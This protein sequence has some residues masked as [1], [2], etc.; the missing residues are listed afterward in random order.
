MAVSL[1]DAKKNIYKIDMTKNEFALK[2][3]KDSIQDKY[4]FDATKLT[5]YLNDQE[6]LDDDLITLDQLTSE[7]RIDN[8]QYL[9]IH[10]YYDKIVTKETI[11]QLYELTEEDKQKK[12]NLP[13]M[14]ILP[15]DNKIKEYNEVLL[16]KAVN[17]PDDIS[18]DF[19]INMGYERSV[20]CKALS[21]SMNNLSIAIDLINEGLI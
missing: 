4:G 5:I 1:I 18:I 6:L 12:M 16:N 10:I 21:K 20:A 7:L 15:E 11:N 3:L 17:E 8:L 13:K 14:N 19:L 2:K 9:S